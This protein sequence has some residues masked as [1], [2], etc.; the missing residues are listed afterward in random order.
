MLLHARGIP[1]SFAQLE[2]KFILTG[3]KNGSNRRLFVDQRGK[4]IGMKH[5]IRHVKYILCRDF[6]DAIYDLRHRVILVVVQE[7]LA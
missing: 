3:E 5:V 2:K 6:P 7:T 1:F 4:T